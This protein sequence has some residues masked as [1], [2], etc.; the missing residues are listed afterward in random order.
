M[1]NWKEYKFSEL[2]EKV[3]DNRGRTCPIVDEGF[4]LIATNCI[5]NDK[6]YPDFVNVR[7][8]DED[9]YNHW[10]RGHPEPNDLIF[11]LKGTPGRVCYT[12]S[13]VSFCIAQDMVALRA[14]QQIVTPKYLFAILRSQVV[15]Q[16]IESLHVGS[17]IPHFKK[18]D[19]D[20]LLVP[21][22]ENRELQKFIGEQYYDFCDKIELNNKI[23]Q[24]LENL[25]QT[26]FKQWFIDFEFPNENGEPYKSSGGE[27]VDSELGE[28]PKGWEVKRLK[29]ILLIKRGGSPRPIQDF[30][31]KTGLPWVKISDATAIKSPFLFSTKEFIKPEGLKKTVLMKK[32]SLV[33]SN[34]ATPGLPVFL[35]LD[36]CI[37]DGWLHFQDIKDLTYNYLYLFFLAIREDLIGQ[38]N[39]SIFVNLK[40]DILKEYKTSIPNGNLISKFEDLVGPL[41]QS[42][43]ENSKEIIELINLRDLILPKLISGEL[44]VADVFIQTTA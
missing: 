36:A 1:T 27:M 5:R 29:E 21:V 34:S 14:N 28:I 38:G 31:A 18:G 42:I 32:G 40:T 44:K 23:N 4:P 7:Y 11:V 12:P 8:V 35:E 6:L 10:F 33:L 17:L 39:G 37:H 20:K 3:T 19:F 22:C 2:L 15:Q 16:R 24:E 26:L 30:I 41:F 25:A 13:P 9:T 43:K